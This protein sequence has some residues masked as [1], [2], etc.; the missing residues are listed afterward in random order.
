MAIDVQ[1]EEAHI[2]DHRHPI[3]VIV[4]RHEVTFRIH[5]ATGREI[6]ETAIRQGVDIQ[7]DFS[8]FR[9]A[10]HH[11]LVPILDDERIALHR[12][13][14]FRAVAPDDNS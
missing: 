2:E 12:N 10:A 13:E 14:D 7:L 1:Q 8:L 5:E 4:N 9:Q 3:A 11:K 6:K